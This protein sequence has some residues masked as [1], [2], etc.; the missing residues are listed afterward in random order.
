[1]TKAREFI[2]F[3][4]ENSVHAGDG[5]DGASQD[6]AELTRRCLEM[7]GD[8]DIS[9]QDINA[10]I[11]NLAKFIGRKLEAANK[12]EADRQQREKGPSSSG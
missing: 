4:I 9:E 3:W 11:G 7:A 2:E 8:Q 10:E 5:A 6:V 1:M 12:V